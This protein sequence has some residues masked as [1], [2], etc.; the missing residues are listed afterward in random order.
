MPKSHASQLI[1]AND[2]HTQLPW[3][4]NAFLNRKAIIWHNQD[5]ICCL[6]GLFLKWYESV[7]PYCFCLQRVGSTRLTHRLL[8]LMQQWLCAR[9]SAKCPS[10]DTLSLN[11]WPYSWLYHVTTLE[12]LTWGLKNNNKH[13]LA[14]YI[15]FALPIYP[16]KQ[17]LLPSHVSCIPSI[18]TETGKPLIL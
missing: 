16:G 8:D 2:F 5:Y 13:V 7:F 1:D 18:S 17:M 4:N 10:L 3:Q 9:V 12:T 11:M 14:A 6:T 15:P